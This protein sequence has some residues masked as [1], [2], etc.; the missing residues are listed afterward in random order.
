MKN[1]SVLFQDYNYRQLAGFDKKKTLILFPIGTIEEQETGEKVV[2]EVR[3]TPTLQE[4]ALILQDVL[5]Q[6]V[7]AATGSRMNSSLCLSRD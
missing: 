4:L 7:H 1:S 5:I 2:K 6:N 3:D